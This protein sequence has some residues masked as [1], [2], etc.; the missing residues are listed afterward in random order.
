M[1][2]SLEFLIF[3]TGII[4]GIVAIGIYLVKHVGSDD[5]QD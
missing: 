2:E 5:S 1:I 4:L 3:A